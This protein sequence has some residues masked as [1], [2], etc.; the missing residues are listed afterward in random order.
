MSERGMQTLTLN[1]GDH[2]TAIQ[3]LNRWLDRE[4]ETERAT[5]DMAVDA[6]KIPGTLCLTTTLSS[7]RV[8]TCLMDLGQNYLAQ[9]EIWPWSWR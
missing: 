9:D 1:A 2:W 8:V 5:L 6:E 3:N 7:G 4:H